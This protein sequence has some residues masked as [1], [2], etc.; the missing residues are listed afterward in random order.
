[1]TEEEKKAQAK[2]DA[3]AKS[4]KVLKIQALAEDKERR[5]KIATAFA[6]HGDQHSALMRDC[7]DDTDC[8]V[9]AAKD[10]LLSALGTGTEPVA[11]DPIITMGVTSAQ[12]FAKASVSAVR[13]RAGHKISAEDSTFAG[14]LRGYSLLEMARK[15]LSINGVNTQNMDKMKLVATAFT[16]TSGDF[17]KILEE[18]ARSSVMMGYDTVDEVIDQIS[19]PV[20]LSDFKATSMVGLSQFGLLD[21]I[22]EGGEYTSGTFDEDKRESMKLATFGKKFSISRQAIIN[23]D[24]GVFAEIPR[25]M[26]QAAK[27]T[28]AD[29]VWEIFKSHIMADGK[30]LFIDGHNNLINKNPLGM[31]GL[32][33]A[34][35]KASGHKD[36][37]SKR[38]LRIT[39]TGLLVPVALEDQARTLMLSETDLGSAN[40]KTPN[41][42]RGA[43]EVVADA[44]LDEISG[45]DWYMHADPA[46]NDVIGIGYLDGNQEPVLE[47]QEGWDTD[48]VEYKVRID[49]GVAALDFRTMTK[50]KGV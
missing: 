31:A 8:T 20:N 46:Q 47:Q 49:A 45:E 27:R 1:M 22:K 11:R 9:A 7:Q 14:E 21:E 16:H 5:E 32:S 10:K 41:I 34:K 33:R 18:V 3:K 12:K 37:V 4:D 24:L 25:K 13:L 36:S 23:D 26:G 42:H 6:S 17:P 43:Y 30:E 50:S 48:G 35:L 29:K 28:V 44:R 19:R 15:S 39:Q 40:S 38:P 2:V